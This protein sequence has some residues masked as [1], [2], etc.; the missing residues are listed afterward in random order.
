MGLPKL[1]VQA[2]TWNLMED[3][4]VVSNP[5]RL[6]CGWWQWVVQVLK[7]V[8]HE[9]KLHHQGVYNKSNQ[10]LTIDGSRCDFNMSTIGPLNPN[11]VING[12]SSQSENVTINT[13][14]VV[15]ELVM[16]LLLT[17]YP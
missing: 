4:Q 7:A 11:N 17:M 6:W 14:E 8:A 15:H 1:L 12:I 10:F 3:D 13:L 5:L 9:Q 16:K 2:K